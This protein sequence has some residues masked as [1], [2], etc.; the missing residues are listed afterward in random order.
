GRSRVVAASASGKTGPA[1]DRHRASARARGREAPGRVAPP[2][3]AAPVQRGG[4][5]TVDATCRAALRA[6]RPLRTAT[7]ATQTGSGTGTTDTEQSQQGERAR[8]LRQFV[9][10]RGGRG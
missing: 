7:Q 3:H 9:G 4:K 8:G 2:G 10:V 6:L 5:S 1:G